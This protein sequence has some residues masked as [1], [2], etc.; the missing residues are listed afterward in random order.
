MGKYKRR[1]SKGTYMHDSLSKYE[2]W[3]NYMRKCFHKRTLLEYIYNKQITIS[4]D[5]NVSN[6]SH[7]A[8][9]SNDSYLH[10]T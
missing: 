5:S 4:T 9:Y 7:T 8:Y 6:E 10:V 3:K 1:E 2:H